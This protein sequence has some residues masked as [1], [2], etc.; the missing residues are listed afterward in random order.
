M[1]ICEMC[2][3]EVGRGVR[4]RV[5]KAILV[6]G[7]ECTRFGSPVES[8]P[9]G[10]HAK[11]NASP[12]PL[13]ASNRIEK[14]LPKRQPGRGTDPL[15]GR[16]E[17]LVPDYSRRILRARNELGFKQEELAAKLNE[18]RSVI[19]EL[20][21]G[22]LIPNDALIRKLERQLKIKLMEKISQEYKLP[23]AKRREMTLGDLVKK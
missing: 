16:G 7:P 12:R 18:K 1:V 17:E 21:A 8:A 2:G 5:D 14:A 20:E 19:R 9:T 6:V 4:I 15:E 10:D 23:S 3:K 22:T 11:R 13:V